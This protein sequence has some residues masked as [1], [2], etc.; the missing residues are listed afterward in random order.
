VEAVQI[1]L[2]SLED[3]IYDATRFSWPHL[4]AVIHDFLCWLLFFG[5]H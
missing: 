3:F 4:L 2:K 5:L 1:L